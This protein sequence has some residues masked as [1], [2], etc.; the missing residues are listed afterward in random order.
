M[1]IRTPL[2]T[3][4]DQQPN[5][6]STARSAFVVKECAPTFTLNLVEERLLRD[7]VAVH[8]PPMGALMLRFFITNPS[9]LLTKAAILDALWPNRF[10]CEGLVKDYVRLLRAKLEDD[11]RNPNYIETVHRRGYRFI[12]DITLV[13]DHETVIK[14]E[15]ISSDS[16]L[17]ACQRGRCD[18]MR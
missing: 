5:D 10:V 18:L 14:N 11:Y 8:L 4:Y 9:R 7:G 1:S 6:F 15:S 12:G 2:S 16:S 13:Q 3:S 17:A